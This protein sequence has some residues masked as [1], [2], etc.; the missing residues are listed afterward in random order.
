MD[1][2]NHTLTFL[3]VQKIHVVNIVEIVVV[4]VAVAGIDMVVL[5]QWGQFGVCGKLQ[6]LAFYG[7]F[8]H[9]GF[10]LEIRF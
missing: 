2:S 8:L 3:I 6:Q 9:P 1:F 7:Q 10:K 5:F 4:V